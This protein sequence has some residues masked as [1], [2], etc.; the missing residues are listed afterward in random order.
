[1][2]NDRAMLL[3]V[4]LR[5][6]VTVL[7]WLCS[8]QAQGDDDPIFHLGICEL[9]EGGEATAE[10]ISTKFDICLNG[11]AGGQFSYVSGNSKENFVTSYAEGTGSLHV[12]EYFSLF[13]EGYRHRRFTFDDTSTETIESDSKMLVARIGNAALH[14][15]SLTA[16]KFRSPFGIG[17]KDASQSYQYLSDEYHWSTYDFGAWVTWDDL[18]NIFFDASFVN[19]SV[20]EGRAEREKLIESGD[21]GGSVRLGYDFSAIEGARLIGSIYAQKNGLRRTGVGFINVNSRGDT[22]WVEFVRTRTTPDGKVTPFRQIIK[23]GY[24]SVWRSASRWS[25]NIEEDRGLHRLAEF[26]HHISFFKH[27]EFNLGIMMQRTLASPYYDRWHATSGIE[28]FL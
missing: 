2:S 7:A 6:V 25:V 26:A 11:R 5:M 1:M 3:K 24:Q 13:A 20:P 9:R 21:W 17:I 19:E 28:V 15:Y 10:S 27:A 22:N 14:G 4:T 18:K 16:G 23:F 12:T 8:N